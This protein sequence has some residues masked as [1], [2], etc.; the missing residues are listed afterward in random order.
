MDE[1]L[2]FFY[3]R[4][5]RAYSF[6]FYDHNDH[7]VTNQVIGTGTGAQ[8]AFPMIKRYTSGSSYYD[9]TITKLVPDS[10]G[11]VMVNGLP[12]TAYTMDPLTG[13]ITFDTPPANTHPIIV[14]SVE[15]YVHAR[16]DNDFAD[17]QLNNYE[18]ETWQD[19]MIV[20]VKE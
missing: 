14:T 19:I 4:F 6:L 12:V 5:G 18:A 3:A 16:F 20:E 17:I 2:A 11:D 1:V 10:I 7:T 8:A 13:I 15:F 9:R